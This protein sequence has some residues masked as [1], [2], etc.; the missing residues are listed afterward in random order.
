M[1]SPIVLETH[2]SLELPLVSDSLKNREMILKKNPLR[3]TMV[4]GGL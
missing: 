1:F 3:K 2:S 4:Q